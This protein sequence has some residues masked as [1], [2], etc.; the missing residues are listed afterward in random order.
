[1]ASKHTIGSRIVIE[2]EKEYNE[3]LR[4][5]KEEQKEL[6]SE[7]KLCTETYKENANSLEALQK[8]S[9]LLT[10]Q[11][12]K[13]AEAVDKQRKKLEAAEK[14]QSQAKNKTEEYKEAL[15]KAKKELEQLETVTDSTTEAVEKQKQEIEELEKGLVLA[16]QSYSKA[17]TAT[18][19]Y[20]TALNN[21]EAEHKALKNELEKVNGYL[22]EAETSVDGCAKS[23]DQYGKKAKEAGEKSEEFGKKSESAITALAS[24]IVASGVK[25]GIDEVKE[26]LMECSEK[27]AEFE[28]AMTKV[29]TIADETA[30]AQSEMAGQIL[31]NSTELVQSSNELA[32]AAYNAISAGVD[33]QNAVEFASTS[34]R[35]AIAGFTDATT[36]V[37]ILTTAINAYGLEMKETTS[38]SD[39]LIT[40]QNE[41]KVTVD[42]L[43]ANMGKVIPLAAA[44]NMDMAN[45]STTYAKLT[46]NGVKT[47]ESTTYIKAMLSELGDSGSKVAEILGEET[48]KSF[49]E[50]MEEGYSLGEVLEFL[51]D[52]VE[53][54]TGAFNELWSSS[55][56]G[57]GAL[58]LLGSGVEEFH[59]VLD[60]MNNSA[61][62]TE[63]AFQEMTDTTEYSQKRMQIALENLQIA[64]GE[65]LN[66]MLNEFYNSGTDVLSWATDFVSNNP[67]LVQAIAAIVAGI[68]TATAAVVGI[69][70]AVAAF[71]A[72]MN[73]TNPIILALSAALGVLVAGYAAL[74]NSSET[75]EEE[76]QK[77]AEALRAT[78]EA[79]REK[80]EATEEELEQQEQ[81]FNQTRDLIQK[82]VELNSKENLSA[83]EKAELADRIKVLQERIPSLT[84]EIDEQTGKLKESTEAFAEMAENAVVEEELLAQEE[85]RSQ[86]MQD[87]VAAEEELAKREAARLEVQE[88]M[89]EIQERITEL[90]EK[91]A[92]GS[93]MDGGLLLS[94]EQELRTLNEEI[95]LLEA[96]ELNLT[97]AIEE[98]N[99]VVQE[100]KTNYD[101]LA[102]STESVSEAQEE[103][104]RVY[105]EYK[106]YMRL[107]TEDVATSI[108]TLN[109][110]YEEA[111]AAAEESLKSQVGLFDELS[112]ASDLTTTE[113]AANL[114]SQTE[115]FTQYKDDLLAA[116]ELVEKGLLDEGLL[117]S[118]QEMGI[119]GAGYLHELVE[120][121][122]TDAEA[123][124]EVVA[125]YEEMVEARTALTETMADLETD[126]T[127]QMDELLGIH[128]LKYGE[129]VTTTED[130]YAE[131]QE[132]IETA[133]A[134]LETTQTE[135][136]DS[137]VQ[138]VTEKYPEMKT[139]GEEL[140]NAAAEGL[141][142]S[143]VVVDDGSSEVFR[144]LGYKIPESVAQGIRDGQALIT[145][146]VQEVID[147]AVSSA[148][149][150]GLSDRID[151]MLGESFS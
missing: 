119:S 55:E 127:E 22:S 140:G 70:A 94:E 82:I 62:A 64:I 67:E 54:D 114:Q 143:L 26:A 57:I 115:A 150:S 146:A 15:E 88:E 102:E 40:T 34:T 132:D 36:S 74:S 47:A 110:A 49:A 113:M 19:R 73:A 18:I 96:E 32:D 105:V 23:I 98:Q 118:I 68:G 38:I 65:K 126:Y 134:N 13:Q 100:A 81:Q 60:E 148:D 33:T 48:G 69:T 107:V 17:E 77:E 25:E 35:L 116:T 92:N 144:N 28:L 111:K 86:I 120:A 52:N 90:Q 21:A 99:A 63:K 91:A 46:A 61:G 151:R 50:L 142:A 133:L 139:A 4:R 137:M 41:G 31:K 97:V 59:R 103:A 24:A 145:T 80:I 121:S 128:T 29:Y 72:V 76:L 30:V 9:E 83:V 5:I 58:S 101:A 56:A 117:G 125:S 122:K 10:K 3:A 43:A 129:L 123:Y 79:Q 66:P 124:A 11:V 149:M 6:R 16:E 78:T 1:M 45:L 44:Y 85:S 135:G 141:E 147:T 130:A 7:M 14:A 136:V 108:N 42:E 53:G 106:D 93:A 87:L 20:S 95:A 104:N 12:D 51:S 138:A 89:A 8:Q 109:V 131:M 75:R 39:M 2:G 84:L 112:T 71:N 27:A 37:D